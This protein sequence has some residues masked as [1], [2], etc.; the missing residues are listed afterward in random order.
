MR[1][2]K[3][4]EIEPE[5]GVLQSLDLILSNKGLF[6][7]EEKES[8]SGGVVAEITVNSSFMLQHWSTQR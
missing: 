1:I 5:K 6:L 4:I 2:A 8:A 3:Q 7:V